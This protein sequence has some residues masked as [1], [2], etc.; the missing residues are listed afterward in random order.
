[1]RFLNVGMMDA[2]GVV[3]GFQ[4]RSAGLEILGFSKILI[5]TDL[6]HKCTL[7]QYG[8]KRYALA[9]I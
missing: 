5:P 6:H 3:D 9:V 7:Q 2:L 8:Q 4:R 1:M